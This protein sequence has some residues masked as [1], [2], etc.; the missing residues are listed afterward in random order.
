[1]EFSL[2]SHKRRM[3]CMEVWGSNRAVDSAVTMTGLDV[4]AYS[5]PFDQ[6]ERGGDVYYLSSC[7]SGRIS[8]LLLADVSGHGAEVARIA[9][10]LR[11]L[12]RRHVN[13]I[14]EIRL[15]EHVNAE[16]ARS[17]DHGGF[18]TA[19]VLTF[20][21]PGRSLSMSNAGHPDPLI[22]RRKTG[23]WSVLGAEKNDPADIDRNLPLGVL[24]ET[25]YT[26]KSTRLDEGDLVLCY[27]DAF[28]ESRSS[29]GRL[30][31]SAGL[32]HVLADAPVREPATVIPWLVER[33]RREDERNLT[34]DDAT[35]TLLTP[36]QLR[37]PL[38]D[39]ILAPFRFAGDLSRRLIRRRSC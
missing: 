35:V 7:A 29:G 11:D 30:L 24:P 6:S 14:S 27:S 12:M 3:Q 22:Y 1:M 9:E 39:N 33:L 19:L 21:A 17:A 2:M 10:L 37:V 31:N 8:R 5:R 34:G 36:N 23:G 20:F 28:S 13:Y 15:A 32:Q 25:R 16:F 26:T 18:A 38:R 4:W